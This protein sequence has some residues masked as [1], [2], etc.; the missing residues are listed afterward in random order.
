MIHTVGSYF[1]LKV[2]CK[3]QPFFPNAFIQT[4]FYPSTTRERA[5]SNYGLL[6]A[7]CGV[8]I[9]AITRWWIP[10][11]T[12]EIRLFNSS[13]R[14]VFVRFFSLT[15][16]LWSNLERF[17]AIVLNLN[18]KCVPSFW[19]YLRSS[20]KFNKTNTSNKNIYGRIRLQTQYWLD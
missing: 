3:V 19:N 17:A 8:V 12:R 5:L 18:F 9:S 14:R 16:C 7:G 11:V 10:T 20:N 13:L 6:F 2:I 4:F 15:P 1:N